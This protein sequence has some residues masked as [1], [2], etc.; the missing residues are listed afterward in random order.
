MLKP[1]DTG[2]VRTIDERAQIVVPPSTRWN[3]GSTR[4]R[5]ERLLSPWLAPQCTSR[6]WAE[7]WGLAG[8]APS[9]LEALLQLYGEQVAA[10]A[11]AAGLGE[12]DIR[13]HLRDRRR[14]DLGV[15]EMLADLNCFPCETPAAR[16]LRLPR[17][18]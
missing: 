15:L 16:P 6:L 14:P 17:L 1:M 12:G 2:Q 9:S 3:P 18:G 4:A 7:T 11:V 13:L 8:V 5:L 10:L